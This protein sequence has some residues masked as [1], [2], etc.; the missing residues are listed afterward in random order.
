MRRRFSSLKA[1]ALAEVSVREDR[2]SRVKCEQA[3]KSWRPGGHPTPPC[4]PFTCQ[5]PVAGHKHKSVVLVGFRDKLKVLLIME[6]LWNQPHF[7]DSH[8]NVRKLDC[9]KV[10]FF[11]VEW[12][13]RKGW[14]TILDIRQQEQKAW[15]KM[16]EDSER[17]SLLSPPRTRLFLFAFF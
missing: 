16:E 5:A 7:G 13:L 17:L 4:R 10:F 9:K 1:S 8:P 6:P 14:K 3:L 11:P 15:E 12:S 2:C